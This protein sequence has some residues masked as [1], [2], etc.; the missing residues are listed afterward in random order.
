MSFLQQNKIQYELLMCISIDAKEGGRNVDKLFG[1]KTKA[2]Q[3][4]TLLVK[5]QTE[6]NMELT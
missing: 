5:L 4:A 6:A 2:S 3:R 1:L